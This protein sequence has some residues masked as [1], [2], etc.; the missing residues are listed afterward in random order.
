MQLKQSKLLDLVRTMGL[1]PDAENCRLRM[2]RE[3]RE[4]FSPHLLQRKPL[5]SATH[6]PWCMSGSLTCGGGENVPG[7][8]GACATRNF[9]CLVRGPFL[10][11]LLPG[12]PTFPLDYDCVAPVF[13]RDKYCLHTLTFGCI[14]NIQASMIAKLA[15]GNCGWWHALT[16]SYKDREQ[17][18]FFTNGIAICCIYVYVLLQ[19][20]TM[21]SLPLYIVKHSQLVVEYKCI[22][23]YIRDIIS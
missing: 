11:Q 18:L 14:S 12:I 2:R 6:V 21:S 9:P 8:P 7:I 16:T 1:I 3:W 5:V 10:T 20:L 4:R 19:T 13:T 15:S 17:S 22:Q 23:Y